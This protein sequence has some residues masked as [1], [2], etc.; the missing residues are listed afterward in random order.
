[1]KV[2]SPLII[3]LIVGN[4]IALS[5]QDGDI[6]SD[7]DRTHRTRTFR[8]TDHYR[9]DT[10]VQDLITDY[11]VVHESFLTELQSLRQEI[12]TAASDSM[13][14]LKDELRTLLRSH[15]K[16]QMEFRKDLRRRLRELRV[17]SG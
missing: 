1:M 16:T 15:R 8:V 14:G 13:V 3:I 17:Q 10:V 12:E 4:P 2:F 11:R 7:G 9:D 6:I 5:A